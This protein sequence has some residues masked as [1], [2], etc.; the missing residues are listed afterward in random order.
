MA[1]LLIGIIGGSCS[2]KTTLSRYLQEKLG[3]DICLLIS[4]D[5]YYHDMQRLSAMGEKLPNFDAPEAMDYDHLMKD[6]IALKTGKSIDMPIYDFHTHSRRIETRPVQARP[7]IILEGIL[8]M[9][10]DDLNSL[11][12]FTY[13]I[14][15][16]EDTRFGRRRARDVIERGRTP[17][18]VE[19]QLRKF[20]RPSHN[21]YVEPCRDKV[22]QIISQEEFLADID[23]LADKLINSWHIE[24]VIGDH[25]DLS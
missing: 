21:R 23:M 17:E 5:D 15:C 3:P 19:V 20:V 22:D 7:I 13:F 18:S 10:R 8:V 12:D 6:L 24:D 14:D 2:G 16:D 11:Y 1:H 4:Q 9:G 25:K